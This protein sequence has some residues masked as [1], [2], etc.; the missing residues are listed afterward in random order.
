IDRPVLIIHGSEDQDVPVDN[1]YELYQ[2]AREPKRLEII[3]GGDHALRHPDNLSRI[4]QLS[5]EWFQQYL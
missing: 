2:H 1:A 4:L 3:Q 5:L